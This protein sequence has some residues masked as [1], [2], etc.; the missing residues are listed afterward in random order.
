MLT[1]ELITRRPSG[2]TG[3]ADWYA[4]VFQAQRAEGMSAA[5]LATLLNV[6][7]TNIY[8]WKRR[9]RELGAGEPGKERKKVPAELVR[10]EVLPSA[11]E[12]SAGD[13]RKDLEVR[14]PNFRSILVPRGFDPADLRQLITTLES[15]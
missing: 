4:E 14:L 8:Y 15:C 9:L 5:D 1:D 2:R 10:V 11:E 13:G 6:T 3:L 7:A 12:P